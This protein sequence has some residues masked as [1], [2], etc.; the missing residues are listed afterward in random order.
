ML[1]FPGS[2]F[3]AFA[4]VERPTSHPAGH[5]VP[6]RTS[7][8][9]RGAGLRVR[10]GT[11]GTVTILLYIYFFAHLHVNTGTCTC[12]CTC[13]CTLYVD[14]YATCTCACFPLICFFTL[15]SYLLVLLQYP[16]RHDQPPNVQVYAPPDEVTEHLSARRAP[17]PK[18]PPSLP[19]LSPV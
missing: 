7:R 8:R 9:A 4:A 13:I 2:F 18:A 6:R 16:L 11:T 1:N 19:S 15:S 14:V 10:E 3:C 5:E 17:A 12:A